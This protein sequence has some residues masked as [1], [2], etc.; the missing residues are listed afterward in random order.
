MPDLIR[1]PVRRTIWN[2]AFALN[3][4]PCRA[5]AGM[6]ETRQAAGYGTRGESMGMGAVAISIS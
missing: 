6:T 4:M 3:T 2:P 1:H 5:F